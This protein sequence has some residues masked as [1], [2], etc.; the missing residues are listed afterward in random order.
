VKQSSANAARPALIIP[1]NAARPVKI[2]P[3]FAAKYAYTHPAGTTAA[4][5]AATGA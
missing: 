5:S 2:T 4:L 1:A 3:V